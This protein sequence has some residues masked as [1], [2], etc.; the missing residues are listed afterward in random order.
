MVPRKK[1]PVANPETEQEQEDEEEKNIEVGGKGMTVKFPIDRRSGIVLAYA[2]AFAIVFGT[3]GLIIAQII[4]A[5]K[6]TGGSVHSAVGFIT[7]LL[8]SFL[9]ALVSR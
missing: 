8:I 7:W 6:L 9:C 1:K 4:T 5:L 3:I 2:F